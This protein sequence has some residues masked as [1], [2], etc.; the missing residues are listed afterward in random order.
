MLLFFDNKEGNRSLISK[1]ISKGNY[2]INNDYIILAM[3]VSQIENGIV[4][5]LKSKGKKLTKN[6]STNL[7]ELAKDYENDGA[8][9][10]GL[11]YINYILYERH[12]LNIR[13]NISHGN[14]FKKNVEVEIM[15][16]I[17]AIMFLNNL[18]RKE[19]DSCD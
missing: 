9:F 5:I 4:E 15:T 14:Y 19:C 17:C 6:G 12:G 1:L 16:T 10:N 11:M 13:N 2:K 7:N 8:Y 18:I 3:N